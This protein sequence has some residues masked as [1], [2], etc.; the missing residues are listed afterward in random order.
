MPVYQWNSRTI[1]DPRGNQA[2]SGPARHFAR[3]NP[4]PTPSDASLTLT[5]AFAYPAQPS[6][7]QNARHWEGPFSSPWSQNPKRNR[8]P[9][10]LRLR[11]IS[12]STRRGGPSMT[13][14]SE[15]CLSPSLLAH[16]LAPPL[17][18]TPS[19]AQWSK[20]RTPGKRAAFM[21][22][23]VET[24]CLPSRMRWGLKQ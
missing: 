14:T 24:A 9:L 3:S 21:K 18:S 7:A 23:R 13:M 4:D 6:I 1:G 17:P 22:R 19:V 2:T 12:R 15:P 16:S 8:R 11:N 10:T 20:R 5:L